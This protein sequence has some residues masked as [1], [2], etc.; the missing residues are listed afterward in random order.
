VAEYRRLFSNLGH[1]FSAVEETNAGKEK[2]EKGKGEKGKGRGEKG[3]S[4]GGQV[5]DTTIEKNE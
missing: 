1:F 4:P 2:G 3:I 5:F